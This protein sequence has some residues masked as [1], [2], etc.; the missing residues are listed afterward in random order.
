MEV[1]DGEKKGAEHLFEKIMAENFL[2]LPK[3]NGYPR[4]ESSK[5]L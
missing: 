2:N 5:G 3:E 4:S 1:S